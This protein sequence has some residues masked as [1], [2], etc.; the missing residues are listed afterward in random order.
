MGELEEAGDMYNRRV[1]VEKI[2]DLYRQAA[3]KLEL[4]GDVRHEEVMT[5]MHEFLAK[6]LVANILDGKSVEICDSQ[7]N[8]EPVPDGEI[9][10]SLDTENEDKP[11]SGEADKEEFQRQESE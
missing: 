9:L 6:P 5:H 2:M 11:S 4:A 1:M 7:K 8:D 3:E 10:E